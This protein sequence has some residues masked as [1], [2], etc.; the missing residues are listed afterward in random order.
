MFTAQIL[1]SFDTRT[2]VVFSEMDG[3]ERLSDDELRY[4]L[5]RHPNVTVG[6]VTGKQSCHY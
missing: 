1:S 5:K 3:I 2:A 6:P 4:E